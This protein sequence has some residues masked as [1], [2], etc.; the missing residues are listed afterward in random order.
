MSNKKKKTQQIKHTRRQ[1]TDVLHVINLLK[2]LLLLQLELLAVSLPVISSPCLNGSPISVKFQVKD[3]FY[4]HKHFF[5]KL[6]SQI[7][8][9]SYYGINI[10]YTTV[11]FIRF[12]SLFFMDNS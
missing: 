10:V 11:I 12:C 4:D 3:L 9:H 1:C 7:V 5:G 8:N 6:V 2:T